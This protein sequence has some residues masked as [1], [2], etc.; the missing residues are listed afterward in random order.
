[1]RLHAEAG[2]L[3]LVP[4][5]DPAFERDEKES[6]YLKEALSAL[7]PLLE[8]AGVVGLV[9]PLGFEYSSLRF[10]AEAVSAIRLI[11]G[12]SV[13]KLVHDTFHHHISGEPVIFP[14]IPA[15]STSLGSTNR[16]LPSRPCVTATAV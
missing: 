7:R 13:F 9:E 12:D 2:A 3:V 10:K 15:S 5:C 16:T 14:S 8:A 1:M 6:E 11:G 4:F